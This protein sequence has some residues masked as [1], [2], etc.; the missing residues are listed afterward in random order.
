MDDKEHMWLMTY[1]LHK[2]NGY[3]VDTEVQND[4]IMLNENYVWCVW[5]SKGEDIWKWMV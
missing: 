4:M 3:V 2:K 1:V 5:S